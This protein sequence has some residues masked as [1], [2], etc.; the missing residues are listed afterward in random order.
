MGPLTRRAA[1]NLAPGVGSHFH[2]SDIP[3]PISQICMLI[4]VSL[5]RLHHAS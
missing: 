4:A 1:E 3:I 5:R 2:S